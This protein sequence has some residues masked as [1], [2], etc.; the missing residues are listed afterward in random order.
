MALNK[1]I[2]KTQIKDAFISQLD[3]EQNT[4]LCIDD[5]AGK[6]ASAVDVYVR[7]AIVTTTVTGTCATPSGAG[8]IVGTGTGN[9]S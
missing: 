5:L 7:S 4:L 1:E 8:T 9:L 6:I 2:L 3:K